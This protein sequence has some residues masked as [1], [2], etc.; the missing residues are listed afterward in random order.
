MYRLILY[1]MI[2]DVLQAFSIIII[3][4]PVVVANDTAP[5]QIR[6]GK[7]WSDTCI[8]SGLAIMVTMWMGNIVFWIVLDLL[9][10]GW[11]LLPCV[12]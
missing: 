10:L 9:W 2:T 4:L 12:S 8:D 6:P 11:S 5:A 3:S 1:L 7:R